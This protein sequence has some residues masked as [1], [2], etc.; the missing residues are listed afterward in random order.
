MEFLEELSTLQKSVQEC[1]DSKETKRLLESFKKGF[2][3]FLTSQKSSIENEFR[4]KTEMDPYVYQHTVFRTYSPGEHY[5]GMCVFF[6]SSSEMRNFYTELKQMY[7]YCCNV[8]MKD[9]P[10]HKKKKCTCGNCY[11]ILRYRSEYSEPCNREHPPHKICVA[12]T[13]QL[14]KKT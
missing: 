7:V 1:V 14:P 11:S 4:Q 6:K 3:E 8:F 10:S 12:F 2:R 5:K 9:V 13:V